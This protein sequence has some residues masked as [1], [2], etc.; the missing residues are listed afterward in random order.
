MLNIL[1]SKLERTDFMEYMIKIRYPY[2]DN[3]AIH[4]HSLLTPFQPCVPIY[5][6][7]SS[8][9]TKD[10][11]P[12]SSICPSANVSVRVNLNVHSMSPRPL[13]TLLPNKSVKT[14]PRIVHM[15]LTPLFDNIME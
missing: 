15:V 4:H 3:S 1:L 8:A 2:S 10:E 9:D 14:P 11:K 5:N 13:T 12:V 6:N 7:L